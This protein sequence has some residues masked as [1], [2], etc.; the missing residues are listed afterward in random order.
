MTFEINRY[1]FNN[2]RNIGKSK[3]K[4][5]FGHMQ[6]NAI[7]LIFCVSICMYVILTQFQTNQICIV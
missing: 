6:F 2:N 3:E 7:R 5:N 1:N 4:Y